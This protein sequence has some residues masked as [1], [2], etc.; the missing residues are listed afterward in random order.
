VDLKTLTL[1]LIDFGSGA[2]V[3]DSYFTDF[4]GEFSILVCISFTICMDRSSPF[5]VMVSLIVAL[6]DTDDIGYVC[7]CSASAVLSTLVTSA[8]MHVVSA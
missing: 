8:A 6:V 1:K 7:V 5:F 3:K 2:F 4:D